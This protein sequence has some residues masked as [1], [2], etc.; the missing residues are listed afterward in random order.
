VL[1]STLF[2]L[3]AAA[4]AVPA[5]FAQAGRTSQPPQGEDIFSE[6]LEVRAVNVQ[7]VVTDRRGNRVSG[8]SA[9]DF[10]ILL[11]G[12]EVPLDYFAEVRE[13]RVAT[14]AG[15]PAQAANA[16]TAA[17]LPPGLRDVGTGEVVG[18]NYL[19]FVDELFS[20]LR[21]RSEALKVLAGGVDQLREEDRMAIVSFNGR[22]LRVLSDWAPPATLKELL[23]KAAKEKRSL[24][25]ITPPVN[26]VAARGPWLRPLMVM[27]GE[28]LQTYTDE[29]DAES[30]SQR[31]TDGSSLV[32]PDLDV[33]EANL[34]IE[35]VKHVVTAAAAALRGFS[36]TTP[37]GRRVMLLLSGGW[38]FDPVGFYANS[39][40]DLA[41]RMLQ[42]SWDGGYRVLRPLIDSSNLLGFTI[43]PIHLAESGTML[44]TAE[45]AE[46][47][48][49]ESMHL[50][51]QQLQT[52]YGLASVAVETGGRVLVPGVRHLQRV[53][54]DTSAYYWLGFS[55][56]GG[57][58]KRRN[59]KV[60]VLRQG[61]DARARS[62]FLP[63][64]RRAKASIDVETALVAG[65]VDNAA[66]LRVELGKLRKGG[67]GSME[68]P[69]SVKIPVDDITLLEE[70]GR[71]LAR[72][73]LRVA[74]LDRSGRR[75]DIPVLPIVISKEQPPAPGMT[76]VY[77]V[78]LK[79]RS[80]A[81]DLQLVLHDLYG[82]KDFAARVHVEP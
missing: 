26:P 2:A 24:T 48:T 14:P 80:D 45:M 30:L 33:M 78:R 17:D 64:S 39:D 4:L 73:E 12:K 61:L 10:R 3:L 59:L 35:A 20:P 79:L 22:D 70:G 67:I 37:P 42:I 71:H 51:D 55:Q 77:D 75:S 28:D 18:T 9:K 58:D 41:K 65:G 43:Y 81:Q 6:V 66:P 46:G 23:R 74:A 13:G 36:A 7:V 62:S 50:Y 60:Q 25:G 1:R 32:S 5:V 69:I 47:G 8:L 72:L 27:P 52:Q 49:F 44:Q 29:R 16:E 76:V 68:L 56:S 54:E 15:E 38:K 34:E 11:D 31:E 40:Y 57:D 19:V 63:L 82:S 21:L 53:E